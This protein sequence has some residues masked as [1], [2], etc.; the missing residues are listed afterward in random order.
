MTFWTKALETG[1]GPAYRRLADGLHT[2]IN[3]GIVRV[4]DRL[5][6]QRELAYELGVSTGTITRAYD[7]ATRRGDVT[8]VTGKGSFVASPAMRKGEEA[9]NLR[10]NLP[11]D[12][13]QGVDLAAALSQRSAAEFLSYIPFGGSEANRQAGAAYMKLGGVTASADDVIVTAGGQHALTTALMVATKP[14]DTI[15]CEPFTFAGFLDYARLTD[16]R[17]VAIPADKEGIRPA[18]FEELCKKH[19]PAAAFLTPTA[20]NPTGTNLPVNR[21]KAIAKSAVKY[22][23]TLIEDGIYDPLMPEPPITFH[24]LVPEQTLYIASLSKTVAPGLRVGYLICPPA[25]RD[26][27]NDI[28]HLLGMGP[29]QAMANLTTSLIA[30]GS[31]ETMTRAQAKEIAARQ[32]Q[33]RAILKQPESSEKNHAPHFWL[34]LPKTWTPEAFVAAAEADGVLVSPS[35]HFAVE[36]GSSETGSN[37]VRLALGA[38]PDRKTLEDTLA[39]L[40]QLL[41]KAPTR[42]SRS[43]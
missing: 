13:G 34:P 1:I 19:Q 14:G 16:R 24:E 6:P 4:G 29:P 39:M 30:T 43:V 25:L 20:Q 33:A 7:L 42:A 31:V 8:A 15:L 26:A 36:A 17:V 38:A 2:A 32:K 12:V 11:A 21:R 41:E 40:A 9:V 5:P 10:I 35:N 28:Q 37:H 3:D 27:A 22:G 23:T 18:A